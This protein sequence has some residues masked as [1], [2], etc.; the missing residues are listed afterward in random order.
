MIKKSSNHSNEQSAADWYANLRPDEQERARRYYPTDLLAGIHSSSPPSLEEVLKT[1]LRAAKDQQNHNDVIAYAKQ[2]LSLE[3]ADTTR[4]LFY[5]YLIRALVNVAYQTCQWD[6]V[7]KYCLQALKEYTNKKDWPQQKDTIEGIRRLR[8]LCKG[9]LIHV[10]GNRKEVD[11]E[12]KNLQLLVD[13]GLMSKEEKE[14]LLEEIRSQLNHR[15]P[16]YLGPE[17]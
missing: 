15:E 2:G 12:E 6:E 13:E 16:T 11:K 1:L 8:I 5:D 10:A 9:E 17:G 4:V 3:V 14:D 7:E